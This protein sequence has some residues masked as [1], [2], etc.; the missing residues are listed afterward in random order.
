MKKL[1]SNNLFNKNCLFFLS[2]CILFFCLQL[3]LCFAQTNDFNKEVSS[4]NVNAEIKVSKLAKPS[5]GSLG[6][7]TDLN[8]LMGLNIWNNLKVEE[9]IEHLNYIPD[10]LASKHFQVFLNDLYISASVPPEG[11]SNQILKLL[12]TRLFKI[13]NSGQSNYL[14]K[15]VLQLP[16]GNRWDIWRKWQI[17]YELINRKDKKACEFI[18][19]ESKSNLKNFWQ[20]ARIFCLSIEGKRDQAEFMLDLIKSR[21]FNDE[22]FEELFQSIYNKV[23]ETNIENKKN[24]IQPLHIVMMDT[25]KMPIKASYIA[26]LG[27]EYTD[28]LLSLNYLTPKARAS[29]LDKQLNYSFVSVDQ[30][31]ENYK[32]VADGSID[33]DKSFSEF[34]KEP[35][36]YN[37]A[38]VWLSIINIKDEI[39]KVHSILKMIKSETNNGRFNDV[40]GLYL[41]L[42]NEIDNSSL[43]QDLNQTI[44]RLKIASNPDLYPNNNF[45]NIISLVE[46]QTWDFNLISKEKAWPLIPIIE[47]AGMIEPNSINWMNH[48]RDIKEIDLE[49]DKYLKWES[50][51]NFKRFLLSKLIK[52]SAK[53]NNKTLT[54]LLIARLIGDNP[55]ID[56][57]LNSL[58]TI[59]NSLNSIGFENLSKIIT[60]EI[61]TSKI[62]N[63]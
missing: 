5:L 9:I 27:I 26:H 48:L 24:K 62:V 11:D 28:S 2:H 43:P 25:L 36:G 16:K 57:D 3:K 20:M 7:K 37:R 46:G 30:I 34:L 50:N 8:N 6:I 47:K 55:L 14:Y 22:I 56:F 29:L 19:V 12:E 33:F 52:E 63:L 4:N 61:M 21:G 49:E 31:I 1:N 41:N 45:A 35:N 58:I 38:N 39:K 60:Q 32:S 18:N 54:I 51:Y 10:N 17:E 53:N 42:L 59:R 13:K 15:L 44:E 40:I 23:N